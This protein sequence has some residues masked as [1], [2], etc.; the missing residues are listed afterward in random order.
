[1]SDHVVRRPGNRVVRRRL[2]ARHVI[3]LGEGPETEGR[4]TVTLHA[5][6]FV[7]AVLVVFLIGALLLM[8]PWST[9]DG[10]RTGFIDALFTSVSAFSVTGLIIVDT[11][12]WD[13]SCQKLVIYLHHGCCLN[14]NLIKISS[15]KYV[16]RLFVLRRFLITFLMKDRHAFWRKQLY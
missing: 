3:E 15:L 8:L 14:Q 7:F 5:K 12:T 1:M 11:Q 9:E 16:I 4:P 2:D 13:T 10:T 6:V